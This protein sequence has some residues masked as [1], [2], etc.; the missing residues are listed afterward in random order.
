MSLFSITITLF[1]LMDPFGNVPIFMSHLHRL[2]P[3]RQRKVICREMFFALGI[4]GIFLYLGEMTLELLDVSRSSVQVAGGLIL[5]LI[6]L[7]MIFPPKEEPAT[8]AP[9]REPFIVPLAVPFVAGPGALTAIMLYAGQS[10]PYY[11][12][13]SAIVLAW[14]FTTLLLL[15]APYIQRVLGEKG[16]KACEILMGLILTLMA[17]QMFLAGIKS[18]MME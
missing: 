13:I 9:Y 15:G 10:T 14:L 12:V 16:M 17:V 8:D 3:K 5:F 4:M 11:L 1:L 2:D 18:F 6:A 7:K